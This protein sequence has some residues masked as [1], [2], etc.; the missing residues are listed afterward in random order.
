M[1]TCLGR[2]LVPG[3]TTWARRRWSYVQRVQDVACRCCVRFSTEG[4]RTQ[5]RVARGNL[6]ATE[7]KLSV[8]S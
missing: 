7:P 8:T 4:L 2:H 5:L 6:G 1:A 3:L